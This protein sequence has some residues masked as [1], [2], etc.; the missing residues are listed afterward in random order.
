MMIDIKKIKTRTYGDKVYTSF[1]GVNFSEDV[2]E[3]ESIT[4]I[5]FDSLL[6]YG[7]RFE[8]EKHYLFDLDKKVIQMLY[9]DKTDLSEGIDL[10]KN[11]S[12]KECIVCNSY[13]FLNSWV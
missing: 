12:S 9:R 11:N 3:C 13:F 2:V 8:T 4:V 10:A 7:N 6:N 5:S 1:G